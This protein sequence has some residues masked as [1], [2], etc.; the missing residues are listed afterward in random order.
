MCGDTVQM[1][2]VMDR[3]K[4]NLQHLTSTRE[5]ELLDLVRDTEFD[6]ILRGEVN[7][8][9]STGIEHIVGNGTP[10]AQDAF[11][12]ILLRQGRVN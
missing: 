7:F 8:A 4:L 11:C 5:R 3:Q 10:I 1:E 2:N 12:S 6:R 9:K